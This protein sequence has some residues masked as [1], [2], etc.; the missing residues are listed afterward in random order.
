MPAPAPAMAENARMS[1]RAF[2]VQNDS[3]ILVGLVKSKQDEEALPG[4]FVNIK[5]TNKGTSTDGNGKFELRNIKKGDVIEVGAIGFL[6]QKIEVENFAQ[7]QILLTPDNNV[8][9]EV[10]VTG[11]GKAP[12]RWE[13]M[14]TNGWDSFNEFI[15]QKIKDYQNQNPNARYGIVK[16]KFKIDE[17]GELSDY[18]FSKKL[19]QELQEKIIEWLEDDTR[20]QPSQKK[21]IAIEDRIEI[22]LKFD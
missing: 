19:P 22:K 13:A 11:Y 6:S 14:P 2:P 5:G 3:V 16:L 4:A 15:A 8:L 10:V 20:W 9:S 21:G 18:K 7:K 12:K 1:K 17:N